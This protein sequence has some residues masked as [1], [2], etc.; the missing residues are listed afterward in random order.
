[1]WTCFK[2]YADRLLGDKG[3]YKDSFVQVGARA[4]NDLSDR[5]HLAYIAN[6]FVD[7]NIAKFF[8]DKNIRIDPKDFALAEMLQWIWRSAIRLD[9]EIWIYIP[10]SRMRW[11]LKDWMREVSRV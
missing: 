6:R 2:D 9:R 10:S 4:T 5:T 8:A 7:P 3:R 11:L 1:M